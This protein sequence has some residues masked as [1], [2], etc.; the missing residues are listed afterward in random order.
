V[1]A[2]R[3]TWARKLLDDMVRRVDL[4]DQGHEHVWVLMGG[5]G[6]EYL[7]CVDCGAEEDG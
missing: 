1:T 7:E 6:D 4:R 2:D 5:P 3:D